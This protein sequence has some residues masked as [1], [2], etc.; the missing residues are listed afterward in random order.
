[1]ALLNHDSH[2]SLEEV[3]YFKVVQV[4]SWNNLKYKTL[5]FRVS[6]M[7]WQFDHQKGSQIWFT[8]LKKSAHRFTQPLCGLFLK[9]MPQSLLPTT[10]Q[11]YLTKKLVSDD[12]T[13]HSNG[14]LVSSPF[15]CP[16]TS[17]SILSCHSSA[18]ALPFGHVTSLRRF[19][20]YLCYG[21]E[22]IKGPTN[23]LIFL[24]IH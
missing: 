18:P 9:T 19:C 15:L 6:P 2:T 4:L 17:P 14:N 3:Q 1:M 12:Q 8:A 7:L 21:T 16:L 11:F 23:N 10:A 22:Q 13:K 5:Y 20:S 24:V